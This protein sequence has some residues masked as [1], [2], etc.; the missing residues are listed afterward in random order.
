MTGYFLL[1]TSVFIRN[2]RMKRSTL[3]LTYYLSS[4]LLH[5]TSTMILSWC[6]TDQLL[7]ALFE[8]DKHFRGKQ[9]K[10]TIGL[11]SALMYG[12]IVIASAVV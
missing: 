12:T 4:Q 1:N 3:L 11:K 9:K 6:C 5:C 7:N 2:A 8:Y 10:N